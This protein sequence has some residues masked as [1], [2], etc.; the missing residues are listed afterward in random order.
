MRDKQLA[1]IAKDGKP[2]TLRPGKRCTSQ[3]ENGHWIKYV[4]RKKKHE[5]M[6]EYTRKCGFKRRFD[7]AFTLEPRTSDNRDMAESSGFEL[8]GVPSLLS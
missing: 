3:L 6:D 8:F 1:K 4:L 7:V 5:S 2:I